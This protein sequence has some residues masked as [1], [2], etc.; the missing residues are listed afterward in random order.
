MAWRN[1][2]IH[3]RCSDY[4]QTLAFFREHFQAKE[5][6]R[7]EVQGKK[8][9]TLEIGGARYSFSPP[10]AGDIVEEKREPLRYGVYHIAFQTDSIV[11]D[12]SRMKARGVKFTQDIQENR[13]GVKCA[14]LE[15]PDGMSIELLQY[16]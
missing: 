12:V 2:H 11:A 16:A 8:M 4:E 3:F 1:D 6:S 14:F 13:P 5:V 15:G 10:F 7:L 9:V